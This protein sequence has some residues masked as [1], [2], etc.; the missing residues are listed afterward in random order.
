MPPCWVGHT[1][2]DPKLDLHYRNCSDA[3]IFAPAVVSSFPITREE[4]TEAFRLETAIFFGSLAP[5][6]QLLMLPRIRDRFLVYP[7]NSVLLQDCR[8]AV[9]NHHQRPKWKR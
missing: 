2:F 5:K 9:R 4:L 3:G 8:W 7:Q 1:V 6:Y